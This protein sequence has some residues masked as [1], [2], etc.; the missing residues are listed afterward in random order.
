VR[1]VP[2]AIEVYK[3]GT[4]RLSNCTVI[5]EIGVGIRATPY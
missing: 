5:E 4:E 3:E 2:P 1:G